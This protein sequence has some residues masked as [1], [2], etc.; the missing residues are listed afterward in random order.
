VQMLERENEDIRIV[1]LPAGMDPADVVLRDGHAAMKQ[2]VEG[3]RDCFTFLMEKALRRHDRSTAEGKEEIIDFLFPFIGVLGSQVRADDCLRRLSDAIA[4]DEA[5]VR[6]DFTRW[7]EGLRL[8]TAA[9]RGLQ[10]PKTV[11]AELFLMLAIAA[12]Q[13]LFP[14]VRKGGIAISDLEDSRARELF[15]ALEE[16][17]RAE[18]TSF[19]ALLERIEDP[20]LGQ[21]LMSKVASG[22]FDMNQERMVAESVRRIK[23]RTLSRRRDSLPAEIGRLEREKTDPSRLKELLAEKMH[24]DDEFAKLDAIMSTGH[25]ISDKGQDAGL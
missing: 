23:L 10:T 25:R 6:T 17:F 9:R 12:R 22:E 24:L 21:L 19:D 11:S 4:A 20:S 16:S 2:R 5:S 7:R 18:E 8:P 13:E 15:V 1:E 14:M 3:A